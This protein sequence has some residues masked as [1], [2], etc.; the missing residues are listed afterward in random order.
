MNSKI[1]AEIKYLLAIKGLTLTYL[2]QEL[3][4]KLGKSYSLTNLSKKL[5]RG[6]IPYEELSLVAEILDCEIKLIVK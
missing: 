4:K 2:A 1:M 5:K 3:S 6:S